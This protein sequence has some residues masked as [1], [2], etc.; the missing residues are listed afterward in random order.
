MKNGR[1]FGLIFFVVLTSFAVFLLFGYLGKEGSRKVE[2]PSSAR[3]ASSADSEESLKGNLRKDG[4]ALGQVKESKTNRPLRRLSEMEDELPQD[5][6]KRILA[7]F[8][9][10]SE[11]EEVIRSLVELGQL[12]VGRDQ[13][14]RGIVYL[15]DGDYEEFKKLRKSFLGDPR[16]LL[17]K[18]NRKTGDPDYWFSRPFEEM[19]EGKN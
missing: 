7:D 5:L 9:S 11:Q 3:H 4:D 17:V 10:A 8:K 13:L 18:A 15:A 2:S 16:D 19:R 12:N 1:S 14:R 6:T